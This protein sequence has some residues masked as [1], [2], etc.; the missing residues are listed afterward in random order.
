MTFLHQKPHKY[1]PPFNRYQLPLTIFLQLS[2]DH[3]FCHACLIRLFTLSLTDPAHMPP[4]C[5]SGTHIPLHHVSPLISNQTK[6]LWNRKYR[7]FTTKNKVYCSS[8]TCG[9][10][11]P[12]ERIHDASKLGK[13][14]KCG[15]KTCSMCNGLAHGTEDCPKDPDIIKFLETAEKEGYQRCYS[16][17]SYVEL[18]RGCNHMFVY[19][20]HYHSSINLLNDPPGV[21]AVMRP[22]ATSAG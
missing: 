16:C 5:C 14:K 4:K 8:P 13:C 12:P 10:W 3:N 20:S 2:C 11:I 6:R 1:F 15:T 17:K 9:E 7:E 21:A 19:P 18:E 22:F